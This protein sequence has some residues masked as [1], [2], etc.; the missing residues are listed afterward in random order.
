VKDV[1]DYKHFNA[2]YFIG[3]LTN[4]IIPMNAGG[5]GNLSLMR[6]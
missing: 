6:Y 3:D 5:Y 2:E 1:R 4:I